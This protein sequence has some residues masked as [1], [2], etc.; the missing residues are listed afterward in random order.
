MSN[1]SVCDA[2]QPS[3][4]REP[5]LAQE[6]LQKPWSKVATDL[7]SINGDNLVVVVDY[8][9]SFR[10]GADYKHC[11]KTSHP[12]FEGYLGE[13]WYTLQCDFGQ[14]ACICL[15]R[16]QEICKTVGIPPHHYLSTLPTGKRQSR[17][18]CENMQDT[19]EE[20]QTS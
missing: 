12:S 9:S 8:Y 19:Y 3:Q 18:C 14:R 11:F 1:R 15:I 16:I 4:A 20:D 17:E 13:S 7:F 6:I 5:L 2:V 10:N